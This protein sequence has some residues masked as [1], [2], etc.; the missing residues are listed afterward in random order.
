MTMEPTT[1]TPVTLESIGVALVMLAVFS[2]F[3]HAIVEVVKGISAIGLW[4][5]VKATYTT[6]FKD[7]ELDEQTIRT[8]VFVLALT[9]CAIFE[10][11]VMIDLLRLPIKDSNIMALWADYIGTASVVYVGV[12]VFYKWI[13]NMTKNLTNGSTPPAK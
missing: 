7:A 11:G 4:G 6:L 10:Y 9:Y 3:I 8:Y 2:A 13:N 12:D 5:I 1:G